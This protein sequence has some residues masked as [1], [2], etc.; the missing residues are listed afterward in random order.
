[1]QFCL[2]LHGDEV[3]KTTK[4]EYT[5]LSSAAERILSVSAHSLTYSPLPK[6]NRANA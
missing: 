3:E 5:S 4:Q 1:M 2:Q 6:E